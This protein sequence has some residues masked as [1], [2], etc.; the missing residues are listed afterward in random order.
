[1]FIL[2]KMFMTSTNLLAEVCN[3]ASSHRLALMVRSITA[4]LII[5]G[6]G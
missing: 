6:R 5:S 2:I 3:T 1:M 4:K